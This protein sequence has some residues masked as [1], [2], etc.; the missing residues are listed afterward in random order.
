M[1]SQDLEDIV[2]NGRGR[3][4]S[5][6]AFARLKDF[7]GKK[8]RVD[9]ADDVAMLVN[10]WEGEKFVEDEKFAGIKHG[11]AR[12]NG[13]DATHHDLTQSRLESRGQQT[14]C[15]QDTDQTLVGVDGE[16]IDYTFTDAFAPDAVE[17]LAHGHVRIQERKIFP[18]VFDNWRIEIGDARGLRHSQLLPDERCLCSSEF[19]PLP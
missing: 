15:R 6:F 1:K 18:R 12:G 19:V 7:V 2:P 11:C 17:R 9:N 4:L 3:T 14:P 16:E 8:A 13:N 10:H 5:I